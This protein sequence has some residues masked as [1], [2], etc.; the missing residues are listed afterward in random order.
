MAAHIT[1]LNIESFRGLE[2]LK[3]EN[4]GDVNIIVGDNNTGKTSV[5]E[6]IQL[7]YEPTLYSMAKIA[8]QREIYKT[9][10]NRND[11]V[12]AIKYLFNFENQQEVKRKIRIE[13]LCKVHEKNSASSLKE[14]KSS[15]TICGQEEKQISGDALAEE[16]NV[17][18]GHIED[19]Y[20]N[21]YD[22]EFDKNSKIRRSTI[23]KSRNQKV[24]FVSAMSH[25]VR[26]SFR[27]I[28]KKPLLT[29][30]AIELLKTFDPN[31]K[32]MTYKSGDDQRYVP[33]FIIEGV[34]EYVPLSVYGDGMKKAL[35]ILNAI[36]EAEDGVVLIDEFETALHTTAMDHV[37]KFMLDVAKE[38]NVQL[39]LATHSLEAIDTLL[40]CD[41]EN[42][43]RIK[44]VRIRKNDSGVYAETIDG[45]EAL[46][47]RGKYKMELRL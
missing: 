18:F 11:L 9:P 14:E 13:C 28:T 47:I 45:S 31:I 29:E 6:A 44:V 7:L 39:F 20:Q 1:S 32:G 16:N 42:I 33:V 8:M 5:L 46:H 26:D 4:L 41:E 21:K 17:F 40:R 22:F 35:T 12:E 24:E 30:Q 19:G 37:F 38:L 27:N 43:D 2:G 25:V 23:S 10:K 3:I 36:I 15:I 34:D